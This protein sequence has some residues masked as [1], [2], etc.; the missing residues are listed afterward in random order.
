L[1][2]IGVL[3]PSTWYSSLADLGG[4]VLNSDQQPKIELQ[5]AVRHTS[6]L[7]AIQA[8]QQIHSLLHSYQDNHHHW[9]EPR[10]ELLGNQIIERT[11]T[12]N[13]DQ[14]AQAYHAL[15]AVAKSRYKENP[16]TELAQELT[17]LRTLLEFPLIRDLNN[18]TPLLT[19]FGKPAHFDGPRHF[20]PER[21]AKLL[22]KIG[23][24]IR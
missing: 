16:S 20:S 11:D 23:D 15:Q 21:A 17:E 3:K 1:S 19:D 6:P 8:Q 24:A 13:W 5:A 9:G 18:H 22:K 12:T 2:T 14:V 7:V 10:Y 4:S